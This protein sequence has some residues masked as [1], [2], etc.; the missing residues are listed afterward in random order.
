MKIPKGQRA[1]VQSRKRL[2]CDPR[3]DLLFHQRQN[4]LFLLIKEQ[5]L[6]P[7]KVSERHRGFPTL[8]SERDVFF[9]LPLRE[10]GPSLQLQNPF[11]GLERLA[12][13]PFRRKKLIYS[14]FLS[15]WEV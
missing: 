8:F 4:R 2:P 6:L 12:Q 3:R 5:T 14:N 11:P 10:V 13:T 15:L 9:R 1:L 7:E